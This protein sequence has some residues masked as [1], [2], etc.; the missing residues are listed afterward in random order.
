MSV[1]IYD[2][3]TLNA[4]PCDFLMHEIH[5]SMDVIYVNVA[6]LLSSHALHPSGSTNPAITREN[7]I[8]GL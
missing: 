2:N 3:M 6:L 8:E 5:I 1:H 4:L 7:N